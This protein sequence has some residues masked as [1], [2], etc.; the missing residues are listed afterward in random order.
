MRTMTISASA[1]VADRTKE[2]VAA[3]IELD[4]GA[5]L[6]I[7]SGE[8]SV[9]NGPSGPLIVVEFGGLQFPFSAREAR[10]VAGLVTAAMEVDHIVRNVTGLACLME[11]IRN[12]ADTADDLFNRG[13]LQ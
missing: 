4:E 3:F 10:A 2:F 1:S 6:V 5:D 11:E 12:A 8:G 7:H 13:T 9:D